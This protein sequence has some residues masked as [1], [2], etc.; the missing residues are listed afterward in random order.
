M[1]VD[2]LGF[3]IAKNQSDTLSF[4]VVVLL[5]LS[6]F[7][8]VVGDNLCCPVRTLFGFVSILSLSQVG[9]TFSV[10]SRTVLD[11]FSGYDL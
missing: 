5:P 2:F 10:F 11:G 6:D 3:F 9:S 8:S 7:S 1:F 4:V